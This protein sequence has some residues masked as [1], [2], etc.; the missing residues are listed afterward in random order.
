MIQILDAQ[1]TAVVRLEGDFDMGTVEDLRPR[2]LEHMGRGIHDFVFDM[3]KAH[4]I[5]SMGLGFLVDLYHGVTPYNGSVRL[6]NV[7]PEIDR[8]LEATHLN[9]LFRAGDPLDVISGML[10]TK[11]AVHRQMGEE[12]HLQHVLASATHSILMARRPEEIQADALKAVLRGIG[13]ERGMLLTLEEH[14]QETQILSLAASQGFAPEDLEDLRMVRLRFDS[15]DTRIIEQNKPRLL[16]SDRPAQLK[17]MTKMQQAIYA[18]IS[19]AAGK[20][21]LLL[22]EVNTQAARDFAQDALSLKTFANICGLAIEKQ[23]LLDNLSG[24]N[25]RLAKTLESLSKTQA[26]LVETGRIAV[27]GCMMQALGHVLGDK[28][29]PILGY[30][31]ML[32]TGNDNADKQKGKAAV[33]EESAMALKSITDGMN[34][35]VKRDGLTLHQH[36][37]SQIMQKALHM[38]QPM[39][40]KADITVDIKFESSKLLHA[41]VDRD[42]VLQAFFALLQRLP[43]VLE[44]SEQARIEISIEQDEES[45]IIVRMTDNG[46]ALSSE[47]FKWSRKPLEHP[48]SLF[49]SDTLCFAIAQS[50]VR[51]HRGKF[52]LQTLSSSGGL[53][54]E[55]AFPVHPPRT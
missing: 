48:E 55:L 50:V 32:A 30:A 39:L 27:A 40:E 18:P 43:V 3:T 49:Q 47:H 21:G 17:Q 10:E 28:L 8:L 45:F 22:I 19:G 51:D 12:V 11:E 26:S 5:C 14:G 46:P 34:R 54:V 6:E 42:R 44:G 16:N 20:L 33:I 13:A 15:I 53:R 25:R 24:K 41:D 2:L 9:R 38:A 1:K 7:A 29:V 31:H 4:F 23:Q 37:I 35:S 36:D 52:D